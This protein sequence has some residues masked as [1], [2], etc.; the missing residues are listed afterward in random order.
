MNTEKNVGILTEYI[1][2]MVRHTTTNATTPGEST[3]Q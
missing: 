1:T 2:T 3:K